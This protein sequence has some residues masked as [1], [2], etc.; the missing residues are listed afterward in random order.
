MIVQHVR[1]AKL[2]GLDDL[3]YMDGVIATLARWSNSWL[4][5]LLLI[6][7][8]YLNTF[9]IWHERVAE[10]W[11]W[12]IIVSG[13][14][15]HVTPAGWYFGLVSQ[16]IYR[17]LVGL[18][19]WKWLLFTFYLFKL[20]RLDLKLV[21]TH[22]DHH[23]GIGFLGLAPMGSLPS[24]SRFLPPSDQ[25]GDTRY[26]TL[27]PNSD[28]LGSCAE[29]PAAGCEI[30]STGIRHKFTAAIPMT[31]RDSINGFTQP[32]RGSAMAHAPESDGWVD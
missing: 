12:A 23:G 25:T 31:R 5:E 18:S 8:V 20:S 2:L 29:R 7:V 15:A 24:R 11:A 9:A 10:H 27:V 4:P 1:G 26:F 14:S 19:L 6:V 22:P 13:G 32:R 16:M 28:T 17:F 3:A 30:K 21:A